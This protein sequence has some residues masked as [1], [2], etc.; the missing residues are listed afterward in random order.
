MVQ[1]DFPSPLVSVQWLAEHLDRPNMVVLDASMEAGVKVGIPGARLFD[2]QHQICDIASGLPNTMPQ[3]LQF[4]TQ[5][6]ALG[7]S[8]TS[9]IVVYDAKG[10][11]SSPRVRWMFKAMGHDQVAV[12]N[13]GLPAW[14]DAG[15]PTA[16]LEAY[17]DHDA[18]YKAHPQTG[19]FLRRGNCFKCPCFRITHGY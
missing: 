15:L 1:D 6:A 19:F 2:F 7:V 8:N 9:Q 11:Y 17:T 16:E 18:V 10:V 4:E 13:G 5:V 14:L 3:P 12:L